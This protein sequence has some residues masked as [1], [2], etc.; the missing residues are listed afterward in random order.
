MLVCLTFIC[1]YFC[2][3]SRFV[4]VF[5]N[6]WKITDTNG[7]TQNHSFS[8]NGPTI[9]T[10]AK[11]IDPKGWSLRNTIDTNGLLVKDH[12]YQW[13]TSKKPLK[14]IDYDGALPKINHCHSIVVKN[15]PS[16][17]SILDSSAQVPLLTPPLPHCNATPVTTVV[18][19]IELAVLSWPRIPQTSRLKN[20]DGA[21]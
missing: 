12:R 14:T 9:K 11:A 10:M 7:D 17:W 1:P 18:K 3:N 2:Y 19:F 21:T 15:S 6:H 5:G 8:G 20:I 13:F 16:L 4:A